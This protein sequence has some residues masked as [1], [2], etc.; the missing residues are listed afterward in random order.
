MR[1]LEVL[2]FIKDHIKKVGYPPTVREIAMACD[3]SSTS[4]AAYY[5]DK[6]END[7]RIKRHPRVARGI[8]VNE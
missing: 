3:M 6:L 1:E 7:R 4:V 2:E 5:L 8:V